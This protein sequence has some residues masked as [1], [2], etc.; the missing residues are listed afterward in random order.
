MYLERIFVHYWLNPMRI[1]QLRWYQS[2]SKIF[3]FSRRFLVLDSI[4][5]LIESASLYIKDS[6]YHQG[7]WDFLL[8]I[9]NGSSQCHWLIIDKKTTGLSRIVPHVFQ[10]IQTVRLFYF[11][12]SCIFSHCKIK[13]P[14]PEL[15]KFPL[16]MSVL[17]VYSSNSGHFLL[18]FRNIF[19][20]NWKLNSRRVRMATPKVNQS[21]W[22]CIFVN[23]M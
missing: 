9:L 17:K 4:H 22:V 19:E 18:D 16:T 21:D 23:R 2:L 13:R 7:K 15:D 1:S 11:S 10:R 12:R 6:S 8:K 5:D 14:Y 20:A 3:R